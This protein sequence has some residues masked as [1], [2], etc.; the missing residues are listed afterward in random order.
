MLS[1]LCCCKKSDASI[2]KHLLEPEYIQCFSFIGQSFI[3]IPVNI[4]DGDT[5]SI[6]FVYNGKP[7]KYK[8]RALGYD[9]PEMKP[10]LTN[11]N[12]ENEKTLAHA[13]KDRFIELLTKHPE[14]SIFIKC[15]DFDK[16][17]RLLVEIWNYVDK[18]SINCIMINEGHGK[19]YDGGKKEKGKL[20]AISSSN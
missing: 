5:L 11:P 3:G 16:Y 18:D 20:N 15:Y 2:L 10:L 7:V 4:Y 12:R 13:A 8:C 17:G 14:K 9:S 6:V 19:P 1:Y